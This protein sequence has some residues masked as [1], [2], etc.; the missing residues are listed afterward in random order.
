[1]CQTSRERRNDVSEERGDHHNDLLIKPLQSCDQMTPI[2]AGPSLYHINVHH[3]PPVLACGFSEALLWGRFVAK[4]CAVHLPQRLLSKRMHELS[5]RPFHCLSQE[6]TS[7]FHIR[8]AAQVF[9]LVRFSSSS[10]VSSA[11]T[12]LRSMQLFAWSGW[13]Q[14]WSLLH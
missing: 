14:S 2:S 13:H 5:L 11:G 12:K 4:C 9:A 10:Y 1:M 8:A 6:A 3:S 7:L